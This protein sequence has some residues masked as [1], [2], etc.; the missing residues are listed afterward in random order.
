MVTT[1]KWAAIIVGA[2][3]GLGYI[4]YLRNT[5]FP[6]RRVNGFLRARGIDFI[7]ITGAFSY[8]WPAYVVVFGSLDK[9]KAFLESPVLQALVAEV[10]AMHRGLGDG[11]RRFDAT[12][13]V[14]V[15][16]DPA[17]AAWY[18]TV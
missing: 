4:G 16:P 5:Y 18:G 6:R 10:Q 12:M 2:V 11:K 15:E 14:S 3:V 13:A 7:R 1:L 8:G 9:S 17:L